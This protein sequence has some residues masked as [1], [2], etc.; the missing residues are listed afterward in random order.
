MASLTSTTRISDAMETT[1]RTVVIK[2]KRHRV[3][4]PA[5]YLIPSTSMTFLISSHTSLFFDGS[6][7]QITR[8]IGRHCQDSLVL[9]E[10]PSQL[11]YGSGFIKEGMGCYPAQGYNDLRMNGPDLRMEKSYTCGHF[12]GQRVSVGRGPAL[13][14]LA[15]KTSG[16]FKP[17]PFSMMFVRRLPAGPTNGLPL[18]RP[19]L[20]RGLAE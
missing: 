16:L 7:K 14:I 9:L 5:F 1:R 18:S 19:P 8:M 12:I 17:M 11:T 4:A 20:H 15:M 13:R 2:T 3:R 6:R 10:C